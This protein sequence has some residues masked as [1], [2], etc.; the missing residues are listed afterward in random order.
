MERGFKQHCSFSIQMLAALSGVRTYLNHRVMLMSVAYCLLFM[1]VLDGGAIVTSYLRWAGVPAVTIAASRGLGAVF[2]L[3][4][5]MMASR[6]HRC[7]GS[8]TRAGLWSIWLFWLL[9]T[10]ACIGFF[11]S[12]TSEAI[13]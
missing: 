6:L 5:T 2:G 1:T 7:T 8:L 10:P 12:D 9:I 3:L 4:V 13:R 11:F